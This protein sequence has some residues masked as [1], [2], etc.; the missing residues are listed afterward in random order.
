ESRPRLC[1]DA[2]PPRV[3]AQE[4]GG[5]AVRLRLLHGK[6]GRQAY[7]HCLGP[8]VGSTKAGAPFPVGQSVDLRPRVRPLL[9]CHGPANRSSSL[10]LAPASSLAGTSL[11]LYRQRNPPVARSGSPVGR[12]AWPQVLLSAGTSLCDRSAS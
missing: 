7:Y 3:Q 1:P 4:G 10:E 12:S 2:P 8:A 11:P 9:E 6:T 5:L